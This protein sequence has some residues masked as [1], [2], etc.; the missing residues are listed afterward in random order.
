M[1][2][3]ALSINKLTK[4]YQSKK[5]QV[6]AL[7][8]VEFSIEK[9]E[10]F[11]LLGPNGAGKS[12]LINILAGVTDQTSGTAVIDGIDISDD[13]TLA[14]RKIGIVPQEIGFDVFFSVGDAMKLQ[15]GYYGLP[16][17]ETHSDSILEKL[18]LLNKK[19][20]KP[21]ELSG[22]MQRRFMIAKAL[23]H[24]PKVLILDEPTAG[25]DVEL[26]HDLYDL[27]RELNA[28]GIT[29]VLTSHYLEEVELLCDRVAIIR[30]GELIA[31]DHKDEL[32][33]RFS[34]DRQLHLKLEKT[35]KDIPASLND[36]KPELSKKTLKLTFAEDAYNKVLA[37]V[38]KSKLDIQSFNVVEPS[39][40][41]VFVS[42]THEE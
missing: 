42:L 2:K 7:K 20:T 31:L 21:R 16:F 37:A 26:R 19:D 3:I 32:K 12:T 38:T 10:V 41:D 24:K 17:D 8:A 1:A 5:G 15:Y 36:F 18:S 9:G 11:G 35:I 27:V 25:V 13:H 28:D 34:T 22:G 39:L 30:K 4:T 6:E 40:E 14:K 23:V 29:I 33:K